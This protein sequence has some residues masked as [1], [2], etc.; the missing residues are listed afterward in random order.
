[1]FLSEKTVWPYR[2]T[3]GTSPLIVSF[4]HVGTFIPH[5]VGRALSDCA[6]QRPDT[7]WHLPLLYNFVH[8]M[9]ATTITANYSRYYVD[10]N[11]P[12]DGANLYPGE[13][14]PRLCPIDTFHSER[15]YRDGGEPPDDE[16]ALRLATV[17]QPYHRRLATEIARVREE[18]G[19]VLLWDAHSIVAE[20]PRLFKGRLPDLNLGT[21]DGTSCDSG[22]G[23]ALLLAL[24]RHA[25]YSSVL[26]GRFKGGFIT[27]K[28]GN[29]VNRVHAVQL[30]LVEA[31]YM[32]ET[33]PYAWRP[34]QAESI[35]P[36]LREALEL[37]LAWVNR[38]TGRRV[39]G[40]K[41]ASP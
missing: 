20:V 5:S 14:T 12:P 10:L 34:D 21:A 8:E 9:G 25:G 16:V 11:R 38:R 19:A 37:A 26:N 7:D 35:R 3:R 6:A 29:P 22:L 32:D 15:L 4:P 17:W 23:E 39:I 40:R 27:R 33:S 18:L 1:M 31:T 13:D 41:N 2:Y 24:K 36:V 30:E 28:Y